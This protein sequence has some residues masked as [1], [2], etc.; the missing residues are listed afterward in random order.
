LKHRGNILDSPAK[1]LEL[2]GGVLVASAAQGWTPRQGYFIEL[3][4]LRQC[5]MK[6]IV[7]VSNQQNYS[8]PVS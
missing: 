8:K 6:T 5:G 2:G 7:R 4:D 3:G 1:Y